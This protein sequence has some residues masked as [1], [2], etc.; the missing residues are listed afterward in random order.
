MVT[1]LLE[2]TGSGNATFR[3]KLSYF[4][5]F[6][7]TLDQHH[8]KYIL[9]LDMLFSRIKLIFKW[10]FFETSYIHEIHSDHTDPSVFSYFSS[11]ASCP[12]PLPS[13]SYDLSCFF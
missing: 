3:N 8:V 9:R 4:L 13:S 12:N 6:D 5:S 7:V 10:L 11:H 1:L 2:A